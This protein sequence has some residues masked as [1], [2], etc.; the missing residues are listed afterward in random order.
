MNHRY[1]RLAALGCLAAAMACA[2]TGRPGAAGLRAPGQGRAPAQAQA[3]PWQ[4]ILGNLDLTAD[5]KAQVKAIM[6]RA[7]TAVQPLQTQLQ[8]TR[9]SLQAAVRTDPGQITYL[10]GNAGQLQG[11]IIGI[12][13]LAMSHVYALLTLDQ[14]AKLDRMEQR[15]RQ[16]AQRNR[17]Q[18]PAAAGG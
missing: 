3:V 8:Q 1:V 6:E 11:Q 13:Q 17:S 18:A 15:L 9:K 4:R 16:R 2:Q 7:R 10:A 14:K 5:Q 12:R